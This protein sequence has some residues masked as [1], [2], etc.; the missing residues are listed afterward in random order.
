[1][2]MKKIIFFV[3]L[4]FIFISCSENKTEV[5]T[6]PLKTDTVVTNHQNCESYFKDAKQMDSILLKETIVNKELA[7]RAIN[8]F[9]TYASE[10]K[11]DSLAP[12]FLLKA[13]QV[14]QSIGNFRQAQI[15][16]KKCADD[17]LNFK[18]RGAALFLLAQ[19]YDN[20]NMLNNEAEAKILYQQIIKEYPKTPW[21]RDS[22]ASLNNLGKTDEQLVQ[23]F[24][25][26]TK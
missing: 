26:T 10:C 16:F 21:E 3:T 2:L 25:K 20:A 6:E 12:I 7:E 17:F 4:S 5:K 22:K 11:N 18:N 19:L 9:N 13:G 15:L 8:A 14:A 23:E 24:L 1:M